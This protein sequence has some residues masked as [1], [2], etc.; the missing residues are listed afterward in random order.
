IR[1]E[2]EMHWRTYAF[3]LIGFNAVGAFAVYAL[4]RWQVWLPLNPQAFGN[5]TPDSSM[6]T[7][8]SFVANTNWQGYAGE[9]TMSYL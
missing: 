5:V 9:S 6:N 3:A 7:A 1:S 4:Q 2:Q 8:V